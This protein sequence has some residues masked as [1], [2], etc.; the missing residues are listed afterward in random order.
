VLS[1]STGTIASPCGHMRDCFMK[2]L[3]SSARVSD[4]TGFASLTMT[5]NGMISVD[6]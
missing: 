6:A 5:T 2:I 1:Q 3:R 4:F